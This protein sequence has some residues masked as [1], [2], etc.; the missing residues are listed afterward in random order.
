MSPN[1]LLL[2]F[3]AALVA[4]TVFL[5]V[6]R[7]AAVRLGAVDRPGW[8][9]VH[10]ESTPRL[11]GFAVYIG[12]LAGLTVGLV[13]LPSAIQPGTERAFLAIVLT[14]T[15]MVLLGILD[16]TRGLTA[17]VKLLSE[18]ALA[19]VLYQ[20][21]LRIEQLSIPGVGTWMLG[22][23]ASLLATVFWMVAVTNAFN[24]I[25]GVSGLAG[26][27]AG[28]TAAGLAM[29]GLLANAPVVV[30]LA[31]A[32][33]GAVLAF[34][35]HNLRPGGIFLGDSGSLYLGFM[36]AATTV[37]FG[38]TAGPAIFPGTGLMLM[39][40]PLV[41]V[42]TTVLRRALRSRTL[43]CGLAGIPSFFRRELMRA[44]AGHLHHCLLRRGLRAGAVAGFL[45]AADA[46]Y[47]LA[48]VSLFAIPE[49]GAPAWLVAGGVTALCIGVCRPFGTPLRG[50][51][52]P[53]VETRTATRPALRVI[54]GGHVAA[55]APGLALAP[56]PARAHAL[57]AVTV[58]T[59]EEECAAAELLAA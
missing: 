24:L 4:A 15:V 43:R 19:L 54:Q 25:D 3:A 33:T 37:H 47:C 7:T 56:A 35:R 48:S 26:G 58:E 20:S 9:R 42:G 49:A 41:E 55:S 52:V 46:V 1:A 53:P 39:G 45:I 18:V 29:L 11:G 12:V 14:S 2:V 17:A 13:V 51:V 23:A 36:L 8:R 28:I 38:Q 10:C 22:E 31:A 32:V 59:A 34:L 40:L 21:G 6:V 57:T 5:P 16:D 30:A 44:D 27:V 50:R